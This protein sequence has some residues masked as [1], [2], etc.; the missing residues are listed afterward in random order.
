MVLG[1]TWADQLAKKRYTA[2]ASLI[3]FSASA[4]EVADDQETSRFHE[5]SETGFYR[6]NAMHP[7]TYL[8]RSGNANV[9]GKR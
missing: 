8:P 9:I 2:L 3:A 4:S 5:C 7:G 1:P 6:V